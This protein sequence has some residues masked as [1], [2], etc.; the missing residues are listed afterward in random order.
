MNNTPA[1]APLL[2]F[3]DLRRMVYTRL[4]AALVLLPLLFF[5]PAGTIRYW[6]A[7]VYLALLLI[8]VFFVMRYLLE[9]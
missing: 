8:P 7:W 5:L 1:D 3:S 6:E 9:T 4:A 2:S